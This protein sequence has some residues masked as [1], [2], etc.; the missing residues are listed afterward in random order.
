[1]AQVPPLV[2][3]LELGGPAVFWFARA[4]QIHSW[5]AGVTLSSTP[6]WQGLNYTFLRRSPVKALG[7]TGPAGVLALPSVG[8]S[9][10]VSDGLSEPVLVGAQVTRRFQVPAQK[11]TSPTPSG[12]ELEP[13]DVTP[14][15][16]CMPVSK[17]FSAPCAL[18]LLGGTDL[19]NLVPKI[20]PAGPAT[21]RHPCG[22]PRSLLPP[23]P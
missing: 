13:A 21:P 10:S 17:P 1:M 16:G 15:G 22:C 19:F 20:P 7:A 18:V 14:S 8:R 2:W 4:H 12:Q 11:A 5:K 9:A 6:F 3:A 23:P